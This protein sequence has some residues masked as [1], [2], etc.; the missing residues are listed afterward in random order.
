M[1]KFV[2]ILAGLLLCLGKIAFAGLKEAED[3]FNQNKYGEA[4]SEYQKTLPALSGADAEHAQFR[5]GY[6]LELQKK[7]DEAIAEYKKVLTI[8]NAFPHSISNAQFRIGCCLELQK[9]YDEAIAEYKKVLTIQDAPPYF[10]S[11]AQF[12]IGYCLE[13]QKKYDEAI[14]EYKRIL[15]IQDAHPEYIAS[16]LYQIGQCLEKQ[17][18]FDEAQQYYLSV[19]RQEGVGLYWYKTAFSKVN[20]TKLG[21]EGYIKLLQDMIFIIPAT[22]ESAEFLGLLKSE[23]KKLGAE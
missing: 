14:A 7:Y 13:L 4:L 17:G 8:Q 22:Q 16:G 23:L 3:L 2:L 15:T 1:K 12:R 9:K 11:N 20:K 10:I 18:K 6:C 21:K 5:I 19:C